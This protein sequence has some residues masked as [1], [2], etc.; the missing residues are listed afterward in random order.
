[1]P[2]VPASHKVIVGS[3]AIRVFPGQ[4][5]DLGS[6]QCAAQPPDCSD[7]GPR[8]VVTNG[9][10]TVYLPVV[11]VGPELAPSGCINQLR[12][13]AYVIIGAVYA[14]LD[15]VTNIEILSHLSAV[16]GLVLVCQG[17]IARHDLRHRK[18]C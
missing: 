6:S 16:D 5:C 1:M 9:E 2:L 7:D 17:R 15:D 4:P 10:N 3:K 14:T 13:Y 8:D 11:A 12:R 18:L